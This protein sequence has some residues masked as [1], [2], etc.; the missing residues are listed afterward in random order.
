[1][2]KVAAHSA[3]RADSSSQTASRSP[4]EE[5]TATMRE[6][7][8]TAHTATSSWSGPFLAR[9]RHL[10]FI[11]A[12][13][14]NPAVFLRTTGPPMQHPAYVGRRQGPQV[15]ANFSAQFEPGEFLRKQTTDV[16]ARRAAAVG[17]RAHCALVPDGFPV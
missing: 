14:S 2:I 9:R 13:R 17:Q 8:T 4:A 10:G 16:R 7:S 3:G 11:E 15:R 5:A 6:E 1:M 12:S